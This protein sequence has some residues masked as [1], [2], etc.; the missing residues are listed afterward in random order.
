MR[1]MRS[2]HFAPSY[3]RWLMF[4]RCRDEHILR[5]SLEHTV[6]SGLVVSTHYRDCLRN[7]RS[8]IVVITGAVPG[9]SNSANSDMR[10]PR[11]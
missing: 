9:M 7:G 4:S 10:V 5:R 2:C 11:M 8:K 6:N 3:R 1:E